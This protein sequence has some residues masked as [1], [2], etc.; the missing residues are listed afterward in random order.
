MGA[1]RDIVLIVG[2]SIHST[3]LGRLRQPAAASRSQPQPAAAHL[4]VSF[5]STLPTEIGQRLGSQAS[6]LL[7]FHKFQSTQPRSVEIILVSGDPAQL[8]TVSIHSTDQRLRHFA[9]NGPHLKGCISIHSH[10][11][12]GE[13]PAPMWGCSRRSRFQSS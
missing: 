1:L 6:P 9:H 3:D 11:S 2:L 4:A 5:Q 8:L 12:V 10:S 13:I 7:W